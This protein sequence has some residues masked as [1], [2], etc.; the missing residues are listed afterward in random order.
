MF[1]H[2]RSFLAEQCLAWL[3][4]SLPDPNPWDLGAGLRNL[5]D[6][7]SRFPPGVRGEVEDAVKGEYL[8]WC[9]KVC[10]WA[11][12]RHWRPPPRPPIVW[13]NTWEEFLWWPGD[14][15]AWEIWHDVE[16]EF[17]AEYGSVW[18]D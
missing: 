6:L 2:G 9:D 17:E 18:Y 4:W 15:E 14:W 16:I 10:A 13:G 7:L 12:R 1:L 5:E 3:R 8:F 11:R